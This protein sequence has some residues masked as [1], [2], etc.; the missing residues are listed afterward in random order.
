MSFNWCFAHVDLSHNLPLLILKFPFCFGIRGSVGVKLKFPLSKGPVCKC[1]YKKPLNSSEVDGSVYWI[2]S[3]NG[4]RAAKGKTCY[5]CR[6]DITVRQADF[7]Q[8]AL[9][10][11]TPQRNSSA[12]SPPSVPF[13]QRQRSEVAD[14]LVHTDYSWKTLETS[15]FQSLPPRHWSQPSIDPIRRWA[16][17]SVEASRGL[18]GP[19]F[20]YQNRQ[21]FAP[22]S[23]FGI[24]SSLQFS[25]LH[26][27]RAIVSCRV[28]PIDLSFLLHFYISSVLRREG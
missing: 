21:P 1:L 24:Q 11:R 3:D 26:C 27:I 7:Q 13:I 4:Q 18:Q 22:P 23:S 28:R 6:P 19:S 20:W 2:K 9:I 25:D 8:F 14:S 15:G 12:K 17:K 16:S 5:W 10:L